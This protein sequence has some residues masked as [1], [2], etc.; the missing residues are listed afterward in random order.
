MAIR[1]Q[2]SCGSLHLRYASRKRFRSVSFC[3]TCG[4]VGLPFLTVVPF[5]FGVVSFRCVGFR[6]VPFHIVPLMPKH[7]RAIARTKSGRGVAW[8]IVATVQL[9]ALKA[10]AVFLTILRQAVNMYYL[11]WNETERN[12]TKVIP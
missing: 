3:K 5:G 4:L 6:F 10:I 11:C 12:E 2:G 9:E 7:R 1:S 8:Q